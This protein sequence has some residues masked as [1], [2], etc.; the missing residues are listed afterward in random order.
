MIFWEAKIKF[1]YWNR[2]QILCVFDGRAS[3]HRLDRSQILMMRSWPTVNILFFSS[4]T[5]MSIT[6]C[7]ASKKVASE[8]RSVSLSVVLHALQTRT[9]YSKPMIG[10]LIRFGEHASHTALPQFL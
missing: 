10:M 2:R 5:S 3:Y 8:G 6:E 1:K 4:S 7:F 9:S